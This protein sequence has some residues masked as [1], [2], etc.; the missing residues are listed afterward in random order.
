MDWVPRKNGL[1][2]RAQAC[3]RLPK[4]ISRGWPRLSRLMTTRAPSEKVISVRFPEAWYCEST[5]RPLT[6]SRTT[7]PSESR[8]I[9]TTLASFSARVKRP[10][11]AYSNLANVL[12]ECLAS[13]RR[14][15]TV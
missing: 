12:S 14:F 10:S 9:S 5:A 15:I 7:R 13:T 8:S 3:K 4:N 1:A 11:T 2:N 6:T